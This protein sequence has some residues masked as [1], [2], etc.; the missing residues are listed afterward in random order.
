MFIG[1]T[2]VLNGQWHKFVMT[3]CYWSPGVLSLIYLNLIGLLHLP[4]ALIFSI[5]SSNAFILS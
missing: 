4:C 1:M 5:S 2:I 3:Y